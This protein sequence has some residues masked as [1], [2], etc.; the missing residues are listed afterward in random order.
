MPSLSTTS[1]DS[2]PS[3]LL[4]LFN[5]SITESIIAAYILKIIILLNLILFLHK[6]EIK[7][8][9]YLKI[10]VNFPIF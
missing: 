6:K 3:S 10:Y 1:E 7:D 4:K 9:V 8:I 2:I 5:T